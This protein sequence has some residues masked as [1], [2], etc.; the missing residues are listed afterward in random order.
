MDFELATNTMLLVCRYCNYN[1]L[2]LQLIN[3][4]ML[5]CCLQAL[6]VIYCFSEKCRWSKVALALA[7]HYNSVDADSR[8][9]I[10]LHTDYSSYLAIFCFLNLINAGGI[11]VVHKSKLVRSFYIIYELYNDSKN[12]T[13]N[14]LKYHKMVALF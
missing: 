12:S 13:L 9:N 11:Y 8:P 14:F 4:F 7:E 5:F 1:V 3:F 2:F 6:F 10:V